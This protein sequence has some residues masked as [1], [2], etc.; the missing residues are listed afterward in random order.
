MHLGTGSSFSV[1]LNRQ[2]CCWWIA[3]RSYFVRLEGCEFS[4][5]I[6]LLKSFKL[7]AFVTISF[8]AGKLMAQQQTSY[9]TYQVVKGD[10]YYKISK[11]FNC[12]V[13][14]IQKANDNKTVI[15]AGET[16]RIPVKSSA[17][18]DLYKSAYQ[19][20]VVV[21]GETLGKIAARYSTTVD[22][23]KKINNLSGDQL[24]IGQKI[25]VP[26]AQKPVETHNDEVVKHTK[27][28]MP[29]EETTKETSVDKPNSSGDKVIVDVNP[30]MPEKTVVASNDFVTEKE[31]TA[32][33]KVVSQKMEDTRTHVMHPTLPKGNIIVVLNPESG[34]M[35]YCKV[36]DNYTPRQYEGSGLIMTPAVADKIG[37]N[38]KIASVKIKY[39]AP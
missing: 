28:D 4:F 9:K 3:C 20:H 29:K 27:N 11:K 31:E 34:R 23:L 6:M 2:K 25:K 37:L 33:A 10:N 36:V 17:R 35:A 8:C 26:A 30:G 13:E 18:T 7:F 16:I 14:E 24:K 38:G 22:Q 32:M 21:K 5:V 19:E 1:C 39:A 15:K 12:S